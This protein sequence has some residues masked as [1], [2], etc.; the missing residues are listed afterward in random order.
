MKILMKNIAINGNYRGIDL[1]RDLFLIAIIYA[2]LS[3][4]FSSTDLTDNPNKPADNIADSTILTLIGS[5]Q[6][7]IP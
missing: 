5:G 3:F 6:F 4:L 2:A 1:I 7:D